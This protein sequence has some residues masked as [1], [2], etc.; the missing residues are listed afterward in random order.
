VSSRSDLSV[1]RMVRPF[2]DLK[3]FAGRMFVSDM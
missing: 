1:L 2:S 3:E